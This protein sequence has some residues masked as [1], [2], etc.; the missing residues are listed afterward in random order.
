[1]QYLLCEPALPQRAPRY[2]IPRHFLHIIRSPHPVQSLKFALSFSRVQSNLKKD[3][4]ITIPVYFSIMKGLTIKE[5]LQKTSAKA[6]ALIKKLVVRELDEE[7]KGNY[8]SFVDDGDKTFDVSIR[9][10]NDRIESVSCDC[11]KPMPCLHVMAVAG[12]IQAP[13][14]K[15]QPKRTAKEAPV[16]QLLK[17]VEETRLREWVKCLLEKNKEVQVSFTHYFSP[18]THYTPEELSAHT[19]LAVKSLVKNKK[20]IDQTILKKI[21][22]LWND[23]HQPVIELYQSD[24]TNE[25]HFKLIRVIVN[26]S[27]YYNF[28]FNINTIKFDKYIEKN[29]LSCSN[30]INSL[31]NDEAWQKAVNLVTDSFIDA[32]KRFNP[33]YANQLFTLIETS[34]EARRQ[35]AF[36]K[37]K[38]FAIVYNA[39]TAQYW[40]FELL[41]AFFYSAIK[42]GVFEQYASLFKVG[43][44]ENEFN[45]T[46][47]K[48]L[49][50][51]GR[52]D[53]AEKFCRDC[54]L[55]NYKDEYNVPYWILL[56]QIYTHTEN[57][58]GL[59]EVCRKLLPFT[60]D[61]NDYLLV[62]EN[63]ASDEERKKFRAKIYASAKQS[64]Y[65]PY[66]RKEFCFSLLDHEGKYTKMIEL[67]Q[68]YSTYYLIVQYFEKMFLTD[69]ARLLKAILDKYRNDHYFYH[70][71]ENAAKEALDK[72]HVP[73]LH[74]L[75]KQKYDN[76]FL[77]AAFRAKVNDR[78][79]YSRNELVRYYE[80]NNPFR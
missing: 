29:L 19:K 76:S 47:I 56:K 32:E 61:F 53:Q 51:T 44:G 78:W 73:V 39:H 37:L 65:L 31:E 46:L 23:I 26:E 14:K 21:F 12:N 77:S 41:K 80:E 71:E 63:I 17:E 38:D 57:R 42:H 30:A 50:K 74:N 9:L 60:Y 64:S 52:S 75:L 22:E 68:Q 25:E 79:A 8:I 55:A 20:N 66:R 72:E 34:D 5:L 3:T 10:K 67:V 48:E 59:A 43:Y 45:I 49:I 54:E 24:V 40:Y 33:H 35:Y 4:R 62:A 6:D 28:Y 13:E 27:L 15:K 69:R 1:M 2:S 16:F 70:G 36:E 11:G 7:G 58:A 18:Q